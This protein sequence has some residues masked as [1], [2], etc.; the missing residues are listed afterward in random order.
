MGSK[1]GLFDAIVASGLPVVGLGTGGYTFFGRLGLSIGHPNGASFTGAAV[2]ALEF[3]A[4]QSAYDGIALPGDNT[5]AVY[6]GAQNGI[7]PQLSEPMAFGVRI[8]SAVGNP[9]LV[10][11]V[12]EQGRYLL[13]GLMPV[14]TP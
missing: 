9:G 13:W 7:G 3:G 10:P 11:I 6:T 4:S 8:A 1:P 5:V 12:Q 2:Q 14:P